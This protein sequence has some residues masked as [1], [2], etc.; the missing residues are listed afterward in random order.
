MAAI[1]VPPLA[2]RLEFCRLFV[3]ADVDGSN[4][5]SLPEFIAI[6]SRLLGVH[7]SE[8]EA[9]AAAESMMAQLDSDGDQ[10]VNFSE[11]M[12]SM[13]RVYSERVAAR[14]R[15]SNALL[16]SLSRSAI[17]LGVSSFDADAIVHACASVQHDFEAA[18]TH[19]LPPLGACFSL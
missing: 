12:T 6:T 17:S 7:L 10:C 8:A 14:E 15:V 5:L 4:T 11:Y 16:E 9:R 1:T 18:G 19:V 2:V 13:T 3:E